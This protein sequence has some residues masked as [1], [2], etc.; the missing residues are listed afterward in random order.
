MLLSG[1]TFIRNA[2]KYDFPFREC[3]ESML[4]IVDELIINVGKSDDGTEEYLKSSFTSSK[5]KY[6]Y[7]TWDDSKIKDGLILSEQTNVALDA[8]QGR[9]CLYLQGDEAIHESE[10]QTI[11]ELIE[12]EDKFSQPVDGFRFRYLHFFGGYTL[13]QRP[14]N[15][16]PSEIR[17]IRRASG[18]RS[19]GDAQTFHVPGNISHRRYRQ[20]PDDRGLKTRL[21]DAHIFHYGH[22]RA[23]DTMAKKIDYFHRFWHGDNHGI[24]VKVGYNVKLKDMVW[25]WWSHPKP[26][27]ERVSK[28]MEW[29]PLPSKALPRFTNV[30]IREDADTASLGSEIESQ[31][32]AAVQ[33]AS[34]VIRVQNAARLLH[35][36]FSMAAPFAVVDLLAEKRSLLSLPLLAALQLRVPWRVAHAPLG[37]LSDHRA[38]FYTAVNWGRHEKTRLGFAVPEAKHA[39][40]I[41]RWL[42][43]DVGF[44][45]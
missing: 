37:L 20:E 39:M 8:C 10:H 19:F 15:W 14:W 17:L 7:S 3:V 2:K 31:L 22:A 41:V 25:Y 4:P 33:G 26:Y 44:G 42:G 9:W 45:T 13:V 6:V 35:A 32:K 43:H 23:P 5:I 21:I 36:V 1:F 24:E 12:T 40:Q 29:S 18:A 34:N 38:G 30:I 11:R 28:G 27:A 16:Y